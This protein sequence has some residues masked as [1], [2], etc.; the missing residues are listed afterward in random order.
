MVLK[1]SGGTCD[2]LVFDE[3]CDEICQTK[4]EY[5]LQRFDPDDE[6][7]GSSDYEEQAYLRNN[8]KNMST[9]MRKKV[10]AYDQLKAFS[11]YLEDKP[12]EL[13]AYR[14]FLVSIFSLVLACISIIIVMIKISHHHSAGA[15]QLRGYCQQGAWAAIGAYCAGEIR[16]GSGGG[17]CG[18]CHGYGGQR[19]A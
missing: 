17:K 8:I 6:D 1:T 5:L 7:I 18:S 19:G 15:L 11:L 2:K 9:D 10:I 14:K 12:A 3:D 4:W 16:V 13:A